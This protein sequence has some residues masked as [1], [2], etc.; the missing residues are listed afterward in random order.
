MRIEHLPITHIRSKLHTSASATYPRG[1]HLPH[2]T[3]IIHEVGVRIGKIRPNEEAIEDGP[4]ELAGDIGF[5]WEKIIEGYLVDPEV[6]VIRVW[7]LEEDG[8]LLTPDGLAIGQGVNGLEV[9][10]YKVI[11]AS[12]DKDIREDW[13]RMAQVKSYLYVLSK[14]FDTPILSALFTILYPC[15]NY[16]PPAPKLDLVRVW[17]EWNELVENWLML[18]N[19]KELVK[20]E[21]AIRE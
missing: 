8:I 13:K 1:T 4:W 10:E 21:E 18:R 6:I 19:N 12:S 9:H 11:W 17:F 14:K 7:E 2:I 15:G 16:R 20:I 3:S 5:L